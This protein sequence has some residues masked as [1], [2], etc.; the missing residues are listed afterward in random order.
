MPSL[1]K[2]V[3]RNLSADTTLHGA[4]VN[5]QRGRSKLDSDPNI[6]HEKRNL[7]LTR[8]PWVLAGN[9]FGKFRHVLHPLQ[10]KRVTLHIWDIFHGCVRRSIVGAFAFLDM[11]NGEIRALENVIIDLETLNTANMHP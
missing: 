7:T 2:K 4:L 11:D 3:G 1:K 9:H 5:N 6:I 8:S 10:I